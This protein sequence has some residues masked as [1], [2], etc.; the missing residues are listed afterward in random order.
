MLTTIFS[1]IL[2]SLFSLLCTLFSVNM[3]FT[4]IEDRKQA[5]RNE[6]RELRDI[7]YHEK[8]LNDFK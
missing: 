2:F 3:I 8:R 7:E 5:K 1:C 6:A 4:I